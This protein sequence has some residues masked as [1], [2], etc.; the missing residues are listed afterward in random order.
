MNYDIA[1]ANCDDR[2]R[3]E[4]IF[5]SVVKYKKNEWG[6]TPFIIKT[7]STLS[8]TDDFICFIY[9]YYYRSPDLQKRGRTNIVRHFKLVAVFEGNKSAININQI[10]VTSSLKNGYKNQ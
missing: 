7:L 5:L 2:V 3:K 1:V 4:V 9:S 8:F 6:K 10:S